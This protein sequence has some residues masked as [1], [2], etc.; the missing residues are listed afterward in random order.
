MNDM[1]TRTISIKLAT[2]GQD[3]ALAETQARFN[4]AATW[5]ASVCWQEHITNTNTA[6][7]RVYGDT[8]VR[9][10]L[11]AQLACCARAKAVEAIRAVKTLDAQR[12]AR[13][14]QGQAKRKGKGTPKPPMPPPEP[15]TCPRFGAR[16]SVRYDARTYRLLP[17][18]RVSL[19]TV[20]G[21][22]TCRLLPGARQHEMLCDPAWTCGGADLVWRDGTY[23]FNVTQHGQTPP[24]I[25]TTG[26]LGVDLGVVNIAT[27]SEG[28]SFTGSQV[29]KKRAAFVARR[30][31]LQRHG[32]RS[33]TRRLRKMSGRERRYMR[34]VNH[35][36]SK[37]LVAKAATSRKALA[38]E[39][40]TGIRERVTVRRDQRYERHTWA[41][42]QLRLFLAYKAAWGGVPVRLVDPAYTSQTCSRCGH[43]ARANRHSQASFLCTSCGFASHADWNAA[44]NISV[45]ACQAANGSAGTSAVTSPRL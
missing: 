33:A 19:S 17:L 36:I 27:D 44:I 4:A 5:I 42:F 14:K 1:L 10:G 26:T 25:E 22:I 20:D 31:A 24:L 15:S 38:L 3:A 28:E 7:R 23:Y 6:H 9:F 34:D 39:D 18:D 43:C 2:V 21:R 45:V 12:L 32:T 8:R 30:A 11:G 40:L 41:F 37:A 35:R 13:W 29:R 16:G